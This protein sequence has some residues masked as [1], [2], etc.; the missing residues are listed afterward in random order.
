MKENVPTFFW[1]YRKV[2]TFLRSYEADHHYTP[3]TPSW[4]TTSR[5]DTSGT[6][7]Q[8]KQEQQNCHSSP[9]SVR[10]QLQQAI[11]ETIPQQTSLSSVIE[12][13]QQQGI[14]TQLTDS[15]WS[16]EKEGIHFAGYQ[17][18]KAFTRNAVTETLA[19][20][21]QQGHQSHSYI[22]DPHRLQY[23]H[24][25]IL[26]P[27]THAA[28]QAG[29]QDVLQWGEFI[30]NYSH[31]QPDLEDILVTAKYRTM[32]GK[33]Q[34]YGFDFAFASEPNRTTSGH[35]IVENAKGVI[36]EEVSY[37]HLENLR[38]RLETE[39]DKPSMGAILKT[40]A[41]VS[42]ETDSLS[43]KPP[44]AL[45]GVGKGLIHSHLDSSHP[46]LDGFD[47]T[48]T[49]TTVIG[50]A[51]RV[52]GSI[53]AA[54]Q[55]FHQQTQNQRLQNLQ[56]AI[57]EASQDTDKIQQR[58]LNIIT[59]ANSEQLPESL[60]GLQ[61]SS[62][63][64]P[65]LDDPEEENVISALATTTE[66]VTSK[67]RTLEDYITPTEPSLAVKIDRK[68]SLSHQLDQMEK[69]LSHLHS[70]LHKLDE[71]LIAL[72]TQFSPIQTPTGITAPNQLA[73][74][75]LNYMKAR[76]AVY[77]LPDQT[78]YTVS[79][80][81]MGKVQVS[82]DYLLISGENT[83]SLLFEATQQNG[84]W[85][86]TA[87]ELSPQQAERILALPQTEAD[88]TK[89]DTGRGLVNYLQHHVPS[90]HHKQGNVMTWRDPEETFLYEFEVKHTAEGQ[91][92]LT[93]VNVTQ[94]RDSIF[95]FEFDDEGL[96]MVKQNDIPPERIIHLLEHESLQPQ[97]QIQR[98]PEL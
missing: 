17:L 25:Q 37:Y 70:R 34:L 84:H 22:T 74:S 89:E 65:S 24:E 4:E 82:P 44:L 68:G 79:T 67:L 90:L 95:V 10:T 23:L 11:T 41:T 97:Q 8:L 21:M 76:N 15:G 98:E 19:M 94:E 39:P 73:Q 38:S 43:N 64:T 33:P 80:R 92:I 40:T 14:S 59:V 78:E 46:E 20:K 13:L 49:S 81:T 55:Q 91:V 28:K 66:L 72:E 77:S 29:I 86:V 71:T 7:Q 96:G 26:K 12:S 36:D 30:E 6:Y 85:Q 9:V 54:V 5:R 32:N 2:E 27:A 50:S 35:H 60:Q 88:V 53:A 3:V 51:L 42:S 56:T 69:V 83:T 57:E 63:F 61:L 87:N 52:G 18:G 48:N 75:W 1:D 31:S 58:L 16:F 45:D 93:G 62:S 47:L